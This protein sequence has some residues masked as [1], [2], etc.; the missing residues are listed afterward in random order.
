MKFIHVHECKLLIPLSY[1]Y[2]LFKI[3]LKNNP[4]IM[5]CHVLLF[6]QLYN[7]AGWETGRTSFINIILSFC[8][9]LLRYSNQCKKSKQCNVFGG[10]NGTNQNDK[11]HFTTLLLPQMS[12]SV[13]KIMPNKYFLS[14]KNSAIWLVQR[15]GRTKVKGIVA[16]FCCSTDVQLKV[17]NK[18]NTYITS[19]EIAFKRTL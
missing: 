2:K 7:L 4:I 13:Q 3:Y 14:K 9:L 18:N 1:E 15:V 19:K 11:N 17:K 8:H 5:Y 12:K 6:E 16:L 10:E